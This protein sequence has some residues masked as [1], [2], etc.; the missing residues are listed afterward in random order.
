MSAARPLRVAIAGFGPFPGVARN[1]SAEIVRKLLRMQRF[2]TGDIR[3]SGAIFPTAYEAAEK[4]LLALLKPRPDAVILFGV[5]GRRRE[6]CIETT[7]RN[8]VSVLAP[9]NA[10]RVPAKRALIAEGSRTLPL[11][12]S[13]H[14]L[15]Q[16]AKSA[17]IRARLSR[18]AGR[19]LCNA[20]FYRAL[21]ETRVQEKPPLVVF[22]HIPM[23]RA[24]R[25]P[26][27]QRK[28]LR[29][30]PSPLPRFPALVRAAAEILAAAISAARRR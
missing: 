8:A 22:V 9:D 13:A 10:R 25:P 27:K 11:R 30:P 3:L 5:A 21:H 7:A 24:N 29:R 4:E 16:A 17:G 19:Y 1:P 2:R 23:P 20:S 26:R 18:D 12:A 14:R 6:V 15:L 28:R